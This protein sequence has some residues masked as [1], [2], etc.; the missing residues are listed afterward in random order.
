MAK[1]SE[2]VDGDNPHDTLIKLL[3]LSRTL[4]STRELDKLLGLIVRAFLQITEAD[5]AYLLLSQD[6]GG[7][8]A[9]HGEAKDGPIIASS[10]PRISSLAKQ[11]ATSGV[12]VYSTNVD[13]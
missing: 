2:P 13:I 10:E 8:K 4:L 7:L 3:T 6:D 12:P 11:V 5:R 9:M 1:S